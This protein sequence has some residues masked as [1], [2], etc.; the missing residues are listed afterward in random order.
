MVCSASLCPRQTVLCGP[1]PSLAPTN[2]MPRLRDSVLL[3]H[4]AVLGQTLPLPNA[5][6][7]AH[8]SLY[9]TSLN[10]HCPRRCFALA[11][12]CAS[13]LCHSLPEPSAAI[14][15]P[16][17]TLLCR[18]HSFASLHAAFLSHCST[19]R[20]SA[21]PRLRVTHR[22]AASAMLDH[23]SRCRHSALGCITTTLLC[24]CLTHPALPL[25]RKPHNAIPLLDETAHSSTLTQP[26]STTP[27]P[28]TARRW[29]ALPLLGHA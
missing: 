10:P 6:N 16:N 5:L 26:L 7:N 28:N 21:L 14:P 11:S 12:H 18:Y 29:G 20:G 24:L 2:P 19:I 4:T 27:Q 3:H 22:C 1:I 9:G 13:L 17:L 23:A 8:T 15:L 25:L